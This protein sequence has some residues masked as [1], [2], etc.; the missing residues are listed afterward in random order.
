[1]FKEKIQPSLV[2]TL[3]CLIACALLVAA[4]EATY[5]DNTGVITDNMIIGLEDIYGTSEGFT[6]KLNE[7]GSVYTPEGVTSVLTDENGN[8]AFEITADGYSSGGLHVMV[9]MSAEGAVAGVSVLSI[10][11]TPGVG[12]RV[13]EDSFLGQFKGLTYDKLPADSGEDTSAKKSYV[14]GTSEEIESL[15]EAAASVPAGDAF[16][17]DAVTGATL[18]SNGMNRA[19]TIALTAY[20]EMKGV[21]GNE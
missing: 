16:E 19:V 21:S 15:K 11:E 10:G 2:L 7:D 12:T 5:V 6:M 14:W 20:N 13:Q 8:T 4:Y 3:I 18:S 17:L 9:G 1:M